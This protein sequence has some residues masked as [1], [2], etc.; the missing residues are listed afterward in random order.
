MRILKIDRKNN[1][2]EVVPDNMDDLWH[3]ER[4]IEPQDVVCAKTERKIKPK[5]EGMEV[6]KENVYYEIEA[7]RIEFHESSGHLRVLGVIVGGKPVELVEMK[8]H[9]SLEIFPSK[10]TLVKKK[11]LKNYQVERLEEAKQASGRGKTLIVVLDD[12]EAEIALLAEKGFET[13]ARIRS[14]KSGKMF[15]TQEKKDVFFETIAK[16][17]VEEAPQKI[18][19]AGPGFTKDNFKKFLE[20]KRIKLPA[21][22]LHTDS[23]GVTGLNE[24]IKSGA[25]E[26]IIAQSQLAKETKLVEKILEELG[27]GSG[28]AVVGSQ[29][30]EK[31]IQ[32]GAVEHF[33]LSD[34]YLLKNRKHAEELLAMVEQNGGKIHILSSKTEAGKKLSGLGGTACLLRYRMNY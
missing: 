23:V 21:F 19:F 2:F 13:K 7:E 8:A 16:K 29:D 34:D 27:R 30:S 26:E 18:I 10:E 22:Y 9:H 25:I 12:E 6:T 20:D 31:A 4:I 5:E 15:F 24:L 33:L 11:A 32:A 17:V 28:M 14:Q 3:L 1:F